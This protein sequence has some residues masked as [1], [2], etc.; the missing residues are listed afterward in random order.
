MNPNDPD[1]ET[2][3]LHGADG[4]P[5]DRVRDS[6]SSKEPSAGTRGGDS[7]FLLPPADLAASRHGAES[8][9]GETFGK[10]KIEALIGAGG[11]GAVY[12]AEQEKPH[13]KVALKVMRFGWTKESG[14][15]RFA[16]EVELLGRLQ[17]PSIAQV[18]DAGVVE[19]R[20]QEFPY[21]TMEFVEGRTFSRWLDDAKPPVATKVRLIAEIA[22]GIDHAHARGVVHRDLKP[23]NVLVTASGRPKI[24]DFGLARDDDAALSAPETEI[25]QVLGTI[26]YMS[27]EQFAGDSRQVDARTDVYAIGAMLHEA[28]TGRLPFDLRKKTLAEAARIVA[29]EEPSRV[30]SIVKELR[31]DVETIVQ[32]ALEKDRARRYASAAELAADLRRYLA[33]EPIAARP[34]STLY[35]L[36]KFA[37]RRKALVGGIAATIMALIVGIFGTTAGLMRATK[38]RDDAVAAERA[39]RES[40]AVAQRN[41][42][43]ARFRAYVSEV[44]GAQAALTAN[45]ALLAIERLARSDRAMRGF[46][47]S[48]FA[49]HVDRSVARLSDEKSAIAV[50]SPE[51]RRLAV[52]QQGELRTID[53]A[54]GKT[55]TI[56][57][58]L[59]DR[60]HDVAWSPDGNRLALASA[61]GAAVTIYDLSSGNVA[62]SA[63]GHLDIVDSIAFS[64]D[65]K[66]LVTGS[67]D[68]TV[69]V[70]DL[71][72]GAAPIVMRAHA[73]NAT[74]AFSRDGRFLLVTGTGGAIVRKADDFSS[75]AR[76]ETTGLEFGD[77]ALSPD[78]ARFAVAA[79]DGSVRIVA[80]ETAQPIEA[81]EGDGKAA[82]RVR[83]SADGAF[84]AARTS[85]RIVRVWDAATGLTRTVLRGHLL[86]VNDVRFDPKVPWRLFT[87]AD[88]GIRAWDVRVTADDIDAR[89]HFGDVFAPIFSADGR[90]I[91]T[92]GLD[93]TTRLWDAVDLRP[94]GPL[95]G[96]FAPADAKAIDK[97]SRL[98]AV[99][100]REGPITLWDLEALR[101]VG[102]L[103]GPSTEVTALGFTRDA[104]RLSA[105]AGAS[106]EVFLFDVA[107]R[108]VID[109]RKIVDAFGAAVVLP[110]KDAVVYASARTEDS[111]RIV[112]HDLDAI[113][114][115]G[116]PKR[117]FDRAKE[118]VTALHVSPDGRRVLANFWSREE[119]L[120]FDLA[121][122]SVGALPAITEDA[123]SAAF[124]PDGRRLC[125]GLAD[126][127][128][129]FLDVDRRE[130]IGRLRAANSWIGGLEF[131]PD[132]A[133]LCAA[134]FD[135]TVKLLLTE[136]RAERL[137]I[138]RSRALPRDDARSQA[139]E[140]VA[141]ASGVI[142]ALEAARQETF[143]SP[144]LKQAV[145]EILNARSGSA[146]ALLDRALAVLVDRRRSAADHEWSREMVS[147]MMYSGRQGAGY[148]LAYSIGC[149]RRGQDALA[150]TGFSQAEN[151]LTSDADRRLRAM[152]M[153]FRAIALFRTGRDDDAHDRLDDLENLMK[154]PPFVDDALSRI[155]AAEAR[156]V[157]GD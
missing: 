48:Y 92:S 17:H 20:G 115:G 112:V 49:A 39:E 133:T 114:R 118:S 109:R 81:L 14:L 116:G 15:R 8:L 126:G 153:A 135:G 128:I 143:S 46:E 52:L 152:I 108:S 139:D 89:E 144:E 123:R 79:S 87:A 83:W 1:S 3:R 121:D 28:L 85:E 120:L 12:L 150:L 32:K 136:N 34:A 130:R 98:A 138:G 38:A 4:V 142:A 84:I 156:E 70:V 110:G 18:F 56:A 47:W 72:N 42:D 23:S 60:V 148:L 68:G 16:R 131:S 99:A 147:A 100:S 129:E 101:E 64:P 13:R 10:F 122:G 63:T 30:G 24:I 65:G 7:T 50:P 69:S 22:E 151:R 134:T 2:M 6:T 55:A 137:T 58:D 9:V 36:Q 57:R 54:D 61:N 29:T 37:R 11:M 102:V 62:T 94:L 76:F 78:G 125:L 127:T 27:P 77:A 111:K 71:L 157:I 43:E 25:G 51:G 104:D 82:E 35:Q 5:A 40:R 145:I 97:T 75:V 140:R 96:R 103:S 149:L 45:D 113:F 33:D 141:R 124:S 26:P 44:G 86:A 73:I 117:T 80:T 95:L 66:R 74:A 19:R 90:R 41:A 21:F 91:L 88:D 154:E 146:E 105:I 107:T 93:R 132:G 119:R 59:D 155:A 31:G 53:F 67:K 106:G